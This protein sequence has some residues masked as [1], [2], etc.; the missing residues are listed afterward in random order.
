MG[1]L[2]NPDSELA[3]E[4]TKWDKPYVYE[5]FPQ[6]V[7]KAWPRENGRVECGDPLV[8]VGD[9]AAMTFAQRCQ[10]V[11]HSA[12][13]RRRAHAEGWR[14]TPAEA[15]DA[16]EDQQQAIATAAAEVHAAVTKMSPKAQAEHKKR[17]QATDTH[18]PEG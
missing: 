16:Y 5:P 18:L 2:L 14:D 8:A 10:R 12:D 13:E 4:L 15:L 17:D 6:M 3:K 1:V 11:V 7:Y 9:A